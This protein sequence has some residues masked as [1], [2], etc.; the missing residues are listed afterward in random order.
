MEGGANPDL[1]HQPLGHLNGAKRNGG[2]AGYLLREQE[3]EGEWEA[4]KIDSYN[5]EPSMPATDR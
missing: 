1:R 2:W 4:E 5:N 3:T